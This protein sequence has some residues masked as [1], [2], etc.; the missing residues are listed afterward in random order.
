MST[1][2]FNVSLTQI[3]RDIQLAQIE[4]RKRGLTHTAVWLAELKIGLD[5]TMLAEDAS[6]AE[7]K[8]NLSEAMNSCYNDGIAE[9]ERDVYDLARSYFDLREYDRAAH[10]IRNT[11]SPV[12]RFLYFYSMYMS[13]EKKRLDNMTDKANLNESGQ[14]RDLSDLMVT[15]RNLYSKRKLDGYCL[16]LYG[17]V[18]KKLDLKE[19]AVTV[20][21]ESINATPTL[22]CSYLELIPLLSDK[23]EIYSANIPNHWMKAIFLA[24]AHVELLLSDKGIKLY[25][26]LQRSGFK[27]STYMVAQIG[28]AFHNKRSKEISQFISF[29]TFES[30][31]VNFILGTIQRC[32]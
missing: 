12:P 18:L 11:Q 22:W 32:L 17:V 8:D 31:K 6:A 15:L 1:P 9:K 10:I 16:Y 25:N 28:K 23:D 20:F 4:C 2:L 30:I 3:K 14:F 21:V 26:E 7:E 24:H 27:N 13:K 5:P 19:L 29:I